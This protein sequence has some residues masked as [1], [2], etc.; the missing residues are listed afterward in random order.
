[1]LT[2]KQLIL[3]DLLNRKVMQNKENNMSKVKQITNTVLS[4]IPFNGFKR[5]I[6]LVLT[7]LVPVTPAIVP[8]YGVPIPAQLIVSKLAVFFG[9]TGI[10]HSLVK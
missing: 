4:K 3:K 10:V 7:S 9:G 1:M 2:K 6:A 8:V 5:T